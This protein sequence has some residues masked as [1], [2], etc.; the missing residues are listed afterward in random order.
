MDRIEQF[1]EGLLE[2][3]H[4]G[5]GNRLPFIAVVPGLNP[6]RRHPG[7]VPV[8]DDADGEGHHDHHVE[9]RD[10]HPRMERRAAQGELLLGVVLGH[11]AVP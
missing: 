1:A 10:Q 2:R 5:L 3:H 6:G 7:L 4:A 11:G 9:Q 8:V